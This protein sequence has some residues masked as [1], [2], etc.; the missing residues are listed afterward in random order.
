MKKI[1]DVDMLQEYIAGLMGRALHHGGN[2]REIVLA[3]V[4]GII[5]RKDG[6]IEARTYKGNMVIALKFQVRG[7]T[8]MGGYQR[9]T[10]KIEIREMGTGQVV[11][12]RYEFDNSTTPEQV[13]DFFKSL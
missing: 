7:Q 11:R 2:V 12:R 10:K 13:I 3:M 5:W 1:A 9:D 8:Y 4:G 6:D